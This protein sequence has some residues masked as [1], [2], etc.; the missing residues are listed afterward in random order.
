MKFYQAITVVQFLVLVTAYNPFK[1]ASQAAMN[2]G[3]DH[4]SKTILRMLTSLQT[5]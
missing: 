4:R 1:G 5:S 3:E 2:D